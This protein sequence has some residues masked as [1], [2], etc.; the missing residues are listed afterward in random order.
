ML[1]KGNYSFPNKIQMP[2]IPDINININAILK[3]KS[4]YF[5]NGKP[6]FLKQNVYPFSAILSSENILDGVQNRSV[7]L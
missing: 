2:S 7:M 4:K 5:L 1:K 6:T 3:K